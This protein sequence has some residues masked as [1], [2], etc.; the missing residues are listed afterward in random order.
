MDMNMLND[1]LP[2][3]DPAPESNTLVAPRPDHVPVKFWD[4]KSGT[5]RVEAL[6]KSY[7]ELERRL[8]SPVPPPPPVQAA[9]YRIECGHGLFQPDAEIN[10]K[11]AAAGF[12]AEQAQLLYDLAAERMMPLLRDMA[13]EFEADR[14]MERLVGHFGGAAQWHDRAADILAWAERNLPAPLVQA[15]ASTADGVLALHRMM[16]EGPGEPKPLR[17]SGVDGAADLTALQRMVAD[18]RYW[19]DRDPGFIAQV[20]DG[21][22]RAYG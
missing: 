8:S 6:L 10:E 3:A 17:G 14:E 11:L 19:R 15:L 9:D 22:R 20:T 18:P 1:T 16:S 12:T 5:I 4:A 7:L 2:E 21:F 13:G